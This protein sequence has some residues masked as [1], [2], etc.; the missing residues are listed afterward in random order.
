MNEKED[1]FEVIGPFY[2]LRAFKQS[3]ES[4]L[5]TQIVLSHWLEKMKAAQTKDKSSGSDCREQRTMSE[6]VVR[7]RPCSL[8]ARARKRAGGPGRESWECVSGRAGGGTQVSRVR[9][10]RLPPALDVRIK[11]YVPPTCAGYGTP[12]LS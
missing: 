9:Q 5:L 10:G 4:Y 8:S 7:P 11:S 3:P 6:W 2:V 1:E 12:F